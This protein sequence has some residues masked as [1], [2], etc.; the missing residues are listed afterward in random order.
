M[1]MVMLIPSND[2]MRSSVPHSSA[3]AS[4]ILGWLRNLSALA[5]PVALP[6]TDCTHARIFHTKSSWLTA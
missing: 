3:K 1:G 6:A 2:T 4:T 5:V